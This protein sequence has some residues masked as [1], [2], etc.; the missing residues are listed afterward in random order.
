MENF[1]DLFR[2]KINEEQPFDGREKSW[3]Q[4]DKQLG[5][6]DAGQ[7]VQPQ[8]GFRAH[9]LWQFAAAASVIGMGWLGWENHQLGNENARLN[10]GLSAEIIKPQ[11]SAPPVLEETQTAFSEKN[12]PGEVENLGQSKNWDKKTESPSGENFVENS[13]GNKAR[14]EPKI[15]QKSE[16]A[17][18]QKNNKRQSIISKD[19]QISS[20]DFEKNQAIENINGATIVSKIAEMAHSTAE[21]ARLTALADSLRAIVL[22]ENKLDSASVFE[23]IDPKTAGPIASQTERKISIDAKP[24]ASMIRPVAR[25]SRFKLGVQAVASQDLKNV[26]KKSW[27][28]GQGLA[29]EFYLK[30]GVSIAAT[31]DWGTYSFESEKAPRHVGPIDT[32][33]FDPGGHG[34]HG[35]HFELKKVSGLQREQNFSLGLNYALPVRFAVRPVVRVGHSWLH[36]SPIS[37]NFRF[38]DKPDQGG[39]GPGPGPDDPITVSKTTPA[40]W[41]SNTWRV[42]LGLDWQRNKWTAG[43]SADL[44]RDFGKTDFAPDALTLRAGVAYS[45]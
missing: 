17:Q 44:S 27:E 41:D 8:T 22:M 9:R 3:A 5:A 18:F 43:F 23:K 14:I 30:K 21:I 12:Q 38:E 11:T 13:T 16:P 37:A 15:Q 1:D 6:F 4:L 32:M 36:R 20:D 42:G 34:G 19:S 40:S 33:D 2:Q 28:R 35:H 24:I 29:A 25:P 10:S 31:A 7:V 45:F 26:D 39:P